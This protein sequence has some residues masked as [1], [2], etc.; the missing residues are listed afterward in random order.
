M[1]ISLGVVDRISS[2]VF[3]IMGMMAIC[4]HGATHVD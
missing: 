4:R 2:R 1:S 3:E